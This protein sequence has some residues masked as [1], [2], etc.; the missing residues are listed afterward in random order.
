M[1]FTNWRYGI[2]ISEQLGRFSLGRMLFKQNSD[3]DFKAFLIL[4]SVFKNSSMKSDAGKE[5]RELAFAARPWLKHYDYWVRPAMNYPRRPLYE[6]LRTTAIEVPDATATVFLGAT[7]TY[8]EIKRQAD[9]LAAALHD[10]GVKKGDC[11]GIMLSNCPQYMIAAF[12]VLRLGAIVVNINPLYTP[13]ELAVVAVDAGIRLLIALDTL[14]GIA[15]E[16]QNQT[17]IET[18]VITSTVGKSGKLV[19]ASKSDQRIVPA[20]A[21]VS[22]ASAEYSPVEVITIVSIGV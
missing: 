3:A 4:M 19:A 7:L 10:A 17:P 14:A 20:I 15:L 16:V 8:A 9:R 6:I 11:I 1:K 18:I 5:I 21:K 22:V 13:R 12:A 2:Q